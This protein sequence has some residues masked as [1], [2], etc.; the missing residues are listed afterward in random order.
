M[1]TPHVSWIAQRR[2]PGKE[3]QDTSN[4]RSRPNTASR[5]ILAMLKRL[6]GR[7]PGS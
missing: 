6:E 3:I 5:G 4:A 7:Y 2:N 1:P